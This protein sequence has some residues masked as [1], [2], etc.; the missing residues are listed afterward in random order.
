MRVTIYDMDYI[1]KTSFKPNVT[2]MKL[3]SYHRQKEDL[4]NFVQERDDLKFD[5]DIMYV[6]R[7]NRRSPFPVSK[8]I[9]DPKVRLVGKEFDYYPNYHKVI[10]EVS[11]CRP[12][13]E[14]YHYLEQNKFA[15]AHMVQLLYGHTK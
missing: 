8:I 5:Y 6:V 4:V 9:D 15:N 11:M 14:S 2:C 12:D 3:V 13:Y 7:E 1:H 10:P